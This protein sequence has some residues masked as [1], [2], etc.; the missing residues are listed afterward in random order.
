MEDV[1]TYFHLGLAES[2]RPN[3]INRR[4][5]PT[6]LTLSPT[7][8]LKVNYI[9]AV[10]AVPAKWGRVKT[11]TPNPTGVTLQP[12]KGKA[13]HVPLDTNFLYSKKT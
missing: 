13:V 12:A 9:M 4:G 3:S 8:P 6:S 2:A 10:A 1:T 7:T 5:I 11:I